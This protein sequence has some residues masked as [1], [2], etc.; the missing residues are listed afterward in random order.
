MNFKSQQFMYYEN[1][2]I[3]IVLNASE[4]LPFLWSKRSF[5]TL[6]ESPKLLLKRIFWSLRPTSFSISRISITI[7][8]IFRCIS[9]EKLMCDI[10]WKYKN[11][12]FVSESEVRNE[13]Y[14]LENAVMRDVVIQLFERISGFTD[15][16]FTLLEV[17]NVRSN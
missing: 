16:D 14:S 4:F 10:F 12:L 11:I 5:D 17:E 3:E 2:K 7:L 9:A 15:F 6:R 8:M 1:R 13:K